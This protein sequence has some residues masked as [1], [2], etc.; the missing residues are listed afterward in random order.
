MNYLPLAFPP[1]SVAEITLIV[2][3]WSPWPFC[4]FLQPE[5]KGYSILSSKPT[6]SV[7]QHWPAVCWLPGGKYLQWFGR[8]IESRL[9]ES[10]SERQVLCYLLLWKAGE[11][12]FL[13]AFGFFFWFAP[14]CL[15]C[16][17]ESWSI[18]Q[19]LIL[20][21]ISPMKIVSLIA[22]F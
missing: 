1:I 14:L 6:S 7:F 19:H 10:Q 9:I 18:C 8:H 4:Y 16:P 3:V 5:N 22:Y 11:P 21:S 13:F 17:Q 2:T 20:I 12:A 15:P